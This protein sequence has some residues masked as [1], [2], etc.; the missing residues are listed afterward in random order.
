MTKKNEVGFAGVFASADDASCANCSQQRE[1]GLMFEHTIPIT[2]SLSG[3]LRSNTAAH[4]PEKEMRTL[5]SFRHEDVAKFLKENLRWII[6]DTASRII[7]DREIL[8][9]SKLE[10]L[11]LSREY[12]LPTQ[13]N[14]LGLY[15]PSEAWPE[16]TEGKVG[17]YGYD[18]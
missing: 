9:K 14:P 2:H 18:A 7:D 16:I 12:D 5:E 15:H 3:Y 6:T 1:E 10:I 8:I 17:G 13:T 11:V 4:G